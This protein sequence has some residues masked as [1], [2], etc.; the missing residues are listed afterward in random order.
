[1]LLRCHEMKVDRRLRSVILF[2]CDIDHKATLAS[3][4]TLRAPSITLSGVGTPAII[5][6][7]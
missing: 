2:Y 5:S 6:S 1:M 3:E 4:G 7:G